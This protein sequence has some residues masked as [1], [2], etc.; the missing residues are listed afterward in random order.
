MNQQ[1]RDTVATLVTVGIVAASL[2]AGVA[3]SRTEGAGACTHFDVDAT[4]SVPREP[5]E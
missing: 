2:A 1:R 4:A 3:I 5:H